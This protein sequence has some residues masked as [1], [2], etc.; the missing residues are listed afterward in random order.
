MRTQ[1]RH[2]STS[3]PVLVEFTP[4]D[5]RFRDKGPDQMPAD[6]AGG[7]VTLSPESRYFEL[8]LD[9]FARTHTEE[10]S[11]QLM[12]NGRMVSLCRDFGGSHLAIQKPGK[13]AEFPFSGIDVASYCVAPNGTNLYCTDREGR[14]F[15]RTGDQPSQQVWRRL[16]HQV[17]G[18][19]PQ[20]EN[21]VL[22]KREKDDLVVGLLSPTTRVWK[23]E[24]KVEGLPEA[25]DTP[26]VLSPS[27]NSLFV[28]HS[29]TITKV[30]MQ[31]GE[32]LAHVIH[33]EEPI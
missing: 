12:T 10:E 18:F 23:T 33:P 4:Q 28:Q 11:P 3:I 22:S 26:V 27:G 1:S 17:H 31:S 21:I 15:V 6:I 24:A 9:V 19:G 25:E 8:T 7:T 29:E 5:R 30:D 32:Q 14:L 20:G 2:T 16:G 13:P